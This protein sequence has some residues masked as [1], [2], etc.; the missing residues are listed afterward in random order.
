MS[1]AGVT[2]LPDVGSRAGSPTPER[3]RS[4]PRVRRLLA[5]TGGSALMALAS[6]AVL[7]PFARLDFD[8]LHDGI[9][10]GSAIGVRDGL[11]VNGEV[12][13]QYGP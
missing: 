6:F 13:A 12:F 8:T 9:M 10:L 4:V 5:G 7:A 2:L 3:A 1:D 11:A